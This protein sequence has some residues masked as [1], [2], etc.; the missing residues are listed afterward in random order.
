MEFHD[1]NVYLTDNELRYT[2]FTRSIFP[3]TV[4]RVVAE[5]LLRQIDE[6]TA[7]A[8]QKTYEMLHRTPE[9]GDQQFYSPAT[10]SKGCGAFALRDLADIHL[11]IE[12]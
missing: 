6:E 5:H 4:A 1:G 12:E 3:I 9:S 8:D 10:L 7:A 11:G 2:G